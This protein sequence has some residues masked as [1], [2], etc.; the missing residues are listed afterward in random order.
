[1]ELTFEMRLAEIRL[2]LIHRV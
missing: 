2:L 1:M